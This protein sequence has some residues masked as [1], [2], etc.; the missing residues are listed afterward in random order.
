MKKGVSVF[1]LLARN[2]IYRI[3]AVFVV[4]GTVEIFSFWKKMQESLH[5]EG[6]FEQV[7][8]RSNQFGWY[9][10]AFLTIS[11]ILGI[12][13]CNFGSMQGY[14]I[15]RLRMSEWKIFWI[16]SSYNL[17][18][19]ILLMGVQLGLFL[20]MGQLYAAFH[21]DVT[22]QTLF[23]AFYRHDFMHSILPMEEWARWG[24]NLLM[25]G[26]MGIAIASV[27]Y[28]QRKRKFGWEAVVVA[29]I[30][31][32]GFENELGSPVP[33]CLTVTILGLAILAASRVYLL[34][35]EN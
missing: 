24:L 2:T 11:L 13:T 25:Y 32:V 21:A 8:E 28:F 18:C 22:S 5:S 23:L 16:Q 26:G 20:G 6:S 9:T 35:T 30:L 29:G 27:P 4:M 15:K 34:V 10:I 19:Y 7:I 33:Y 1:A 12:S 17:M 3:L 14:T 31:A